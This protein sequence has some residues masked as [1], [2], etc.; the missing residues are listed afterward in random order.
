MGNSFCCPSKRREMLEN[1][2]AE[3][4]QYS[5]TTPAEGLLKGP[6]IKP[7]TPEWVKTQETRKIYITN[8]GLSN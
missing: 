1:V 8:L 4:F 5:F 7:L 2:L 3:G 6:G